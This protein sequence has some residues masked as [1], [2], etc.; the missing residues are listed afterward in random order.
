MCRSSC[1]HMRVRVWIHALAPCDDCVI[2]VQ[3]TTK[4]EISAKRE[5]LQ[6]MLSSLRMLSVGVASVDSNEDKALV[7]DH[8]QAP[9]PPTARP[10][11]P[12]AC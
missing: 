4:D 12:I 3:S 6:S 7:L 2:Y 5:P 11:L 8:E 9:P 1:V 10:S